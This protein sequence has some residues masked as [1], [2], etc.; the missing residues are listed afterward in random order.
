[1]KRK[2]FPGRK[3]QRRKVALENM[4][5]RA[6][7]IKNTLDDLRKKRKALKGSK[8]KRQQEAQDLDRRIENLEADHARLTD[9]IMRTQA[10]MVAGFSRGF[11]EVAKAFNKLGAETSRT[12]AQVANFARVYAAG[13]GK[14]DPVGEQAMKLARAAN[15]SYEDG[16]R[17]IESIITG[18]DAIT[19]SGEVLE[20]KTTH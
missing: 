19:P 8:R 13:A 3:N 18:P 2:N 10:K 5:I 16:R 15:L 11:P 12:Q 7:A 6:A 1:M 20:H 4:G 14:R 17:A 9:V